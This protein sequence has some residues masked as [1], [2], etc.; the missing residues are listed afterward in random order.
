MAATRCLVALAL[1]ALPGGCVWWPDIEEREDILVGPTIDRLKVDPPLDRVVELTTIS[2]EFSVV[3]A[4]TDPDTPIEMLEYQWYVGYPESNPRRGPDFIG[5]QSIRFNPCAFKTEFETF[6]A[7][8][9]LELIVS[10]QPIEFDPE[11]GRIIKGGY[12]YISW[13]FDP[14]KV[15]CQ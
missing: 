6:Y 15:V 8:H 1:V 5:Q 13:T 7:P 12:A 11:Q 3:G 2:T 9:L 10:D 14:V 4:L